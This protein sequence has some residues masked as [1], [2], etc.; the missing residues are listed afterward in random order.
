MTSFAAYP[1]KS[2]LETPALEVV[3][4]LLLQVYQQV[5]TP[6]RQVRLEH[7]IVFL[8]ELIKERALGAVAHTRRRAHPNWLPC[9]PAKA[10]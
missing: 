9:Q 5:R 10:R 7:G 6:R 8:D 4:E 2:G 1:Q 3:L